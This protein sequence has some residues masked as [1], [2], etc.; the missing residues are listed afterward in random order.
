MATYD[1]AGQIGVPF[2]VAAPPATAEAIASLHDI[3]AE[4]QRMLETTRGLFGD[5]V[6]LVLEQDPEV[7]SDTQ[8]VFEV[9]TRGD[10]DQVLAKEDKWHA[11]C[12]QLPNNASRFFRL[13]VDV[14]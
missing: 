7:P 3:S 6:Q 10:V 1:Q 8:L 4:L 9:T 5:G 2:P 11:C 14:L 12:V 13:H